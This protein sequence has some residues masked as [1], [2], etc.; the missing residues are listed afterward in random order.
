MKRKN[1]LLTAIASIAFVTTTLAQ[2]PSYV[3]TNGLVGWWPLD[4]NA[5]DISG[6]GY[7]GT[8]LNGVASTTDR[9]SNSNSAY[10]FDGTNDRIYINNNFFDNGWSEHTISIWTNINSVANPNN[11]NSSHVLFNT[12]AHNGLALGMNWGSSSKYHLYVGNGTPAT[13]WNAVSSPASTQ[14]ITASTWKL[15]TLVKSANIY[16]LY[17]NATFAQSWTSSVTIQSYLYK[18]YFGS[19]DP[20]VGSEVINGKLD[21]IGIW[22][23]ALTSTEITALYNAC[24]P[25]SANINTTS[26][27]TFCIGQ[28]AVLN[29]NKSGSPYTLQWKLNTTNISSATLSSY[30]AT[31][32]GTYTLVVDSLGCKGTSAPINIVVNPLPIVSITNLGTYISYNAPAITLIGNPTGGSFSGSGVSVSTFTASAA[33]LGTKNITYSYTDGNGCSNSANKQTIVYD[34][35]GVVCTSY[36]T[37]TTYTS[38]ADTLIIN[39]N[40]TGVAAPNNVNILKV[41]PNPANDHI[42]IDLGN[43]A[44]MSGYTVK[45]KN[46]LGQEVYS[47]PVTQQ[48]EYIDLNGWSGNG[49]YFMNVID[50]SNNTLEIKKI[51]LQ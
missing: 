2:V 31:Q 7:N 48:T 43:Y 50:A 41:Y 32:T 47:A 20:A 23:R 27:L 44:S 28:N 6:N 10:S 5:N 17:I 18:M 42:T 34:T 30:T 8:L 49:T 38:V 36:T 21:D 1:L 9:F 12:S 51:V 29:S 46:N 19:T 22:N 15:A 3:P 14:S 25:V 39:V 33:G 4:G 16:S 40:L 11:A 26:P 37:I 13:S 24:P 45:I 35:L